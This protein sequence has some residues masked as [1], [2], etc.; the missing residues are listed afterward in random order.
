M[1]FSQS[2]LDALRHTLFRDDPVPVNIIL[3]TVA[4]F[5]GV[6]LVVFVQRRSTHRSGDVYARGRVE[7]EAEDAVTHV[8][9]DFS[10]GAGQAS[11]S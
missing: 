3:L 8:V 4:L 7:R 5:I 11:S 10:M 9:P 2:G 6:T 1:N